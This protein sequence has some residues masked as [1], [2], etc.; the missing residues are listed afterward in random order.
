MRTPNLAVGVGERFG[1]LVVL[2]VWIGRRQWAECLCDCGAR[3]A[4]IGHS[5]RAGVTRSC[6]CMSSERM[7]GRNITHGESVRGLHTPEYQTW[8]AMFKRCR[9][10]G[11]T[12]FKNYGARG[13]TVC[14]RWTG[15]GGFLLFLE[16][17]GRRPSDKHS[18]DRIDNDGHYEPRNCRWATASEQAKN[19]RERERDDSGR[20]VAKS[21][22]EEVAK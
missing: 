19:R 16:D 18:I 10:P 3:T 13:I 14:D 12:G 7:R 4:T 5:L 21:H 20:W 1:R 15:E 2:R 8:S 6:G 22:V 11:N 17:M 9:N